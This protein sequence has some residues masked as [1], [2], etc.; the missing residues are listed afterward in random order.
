MNSVF[1]ILVHANSPLLK[2]L[3]N[4]LSKF[5]STIYLQIDLKSNSL[6]FDEYQKL[7]NVFFIKKRISITW[8]AYSQVQ[9]MVNSFKEIIE[10]NNKDQYVSV[11]SGQDYPLMNCDEM[12]R[13]LAANQG[14]AFM[15]FYPIYDE[16]TE[17]IMR[18]EKF[19][20]TDFLFLGKSKIESLLNFILPKRV[21]PKEL[22]YVGR[23]SWFTVTV[24]HLSFI[25]DFLETKPSIKRFFSLTWGC[26]EIIFQTILFNSKYQSQMVN[27]NLRYIDWTL[28]GSRPK[29][30][31]MQD[32][33]Q[34][35][36]SGKFFARKF[37]TNV[38]SQI[39]DWIDDNLLT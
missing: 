11:I 15:E 35:G 14:K 24:E 8:G 4:T 22:V 26:D 5:N 23:S 36:M 13:F 19:H 3:I 31:R 33:D 37:D 16:W 21:P 27:N 7:P 25:V 29:I 10:H 12:N 1:L 2:R 6:F 9:G 20:L 39:L 34:I 30:L 17:A 32:A 28:G 18:L 38:D